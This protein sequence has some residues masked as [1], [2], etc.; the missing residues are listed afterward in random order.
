MKGTIHVLKFIVTHLDYFSCN[1]N[2]NISANMSTNISANMGSYGFSNATGNND[3][4]SNHSLNSTI[5]SGRTSSRK[6]KKKRCGVLLPHGGFPLVPASLSTMAW[7][8]SLFQ[9]GCD[10][11]RLTGVSLTALNNST[12]F[13]FAEIGFESYRVPIHNFEKDEWTIRYTDRCLDYKAPDVNGEEIKFDLY[14]KVGKMMHLL[15]T[16]FGGAGTLLLWFAAIFM[17]FTKTQW[18]WA[19]FE[20]AIASLFQFFSFL[21]FFNN[22]CSAS[23][24]HCHLFFGSTLNIVSII[25]Y[26]T[27]SAIIC[28]K[29]PEPKTVKFLKKR[30]DESYHNYD[31]TPLTSATS[32]PSVYG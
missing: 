27:A 24:S 6:N 14:W 4:R 25:L 26:L 1:I 9:D 23:G 12:D 30:M 5:R 8:A 7:L 21:W 16:I 10:F 18:R 11:A 28:L 15:A 3:N 13:P 17:A 31:E 29:Y 32:N 20:C 22:F 2:P 19:A